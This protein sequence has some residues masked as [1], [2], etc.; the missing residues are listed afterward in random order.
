MSKRKSTK[1]AG[2]AEAFAER[3][4]KGVEIVKQQREN[5]PFKDYVPDRTALFNASGSHEIRTRNLEG[6]YK[7]RLSFCIA[8]NEI[9]L[10]HYGSI[11]SG[12]VMV[13]P[14]QDKRV[15]CDS[16]YRYVRSVAR[17]VVYD[18]FKYDRFC[19][20]CAGP[21][22][23]EK[24]IQVNALR[25]LAIERAKKPLNLSDPDSIATAFDA[26]SFM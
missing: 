25:E 19:E 24:E 17:V 10:C 15:R 11:G 13:H 5:P 21:D 9:T 18:D 23:R 6:I 2:V 4:K 26:S 8:C 16:C 3:L 12:C 14:R 7:L 20:L 1:A 22:S